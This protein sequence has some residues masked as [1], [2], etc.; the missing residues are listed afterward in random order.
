M[1]VLC[2][3]QAPEVEEAPKVK[4][5]KEATVKTEEPD[6][7]SACVCVRVSKANTTDPIDCFISCWGEKTSYFA[8]ICKQR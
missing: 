7:V 1:S 5:E 2:N 4:E 8:D 3:S 6:D